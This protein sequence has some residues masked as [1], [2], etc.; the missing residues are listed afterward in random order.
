MFY[1]IEGRLIQVAFFLIFFGYI[2]WLVE[3]NSPYWGTT[4][5]GYAY[6][7]R[8]VLIWI[9]SL[10]F[11]KPPVQPFKGIKQFAESSVVENDVEE[12]THQ[13]DNNGIDPESRMVNP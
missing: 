13:P 2:A 5:T 8:V 6:P 7:V 10:L 4:L 9:I 3:N 1:N 12:Y 11:I